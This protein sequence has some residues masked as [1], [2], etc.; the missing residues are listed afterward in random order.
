MPASVRPKRFLREHIPAER[1]VEVHLVVDGTSSQRAVDRKVALKVPLTVLLLQVMIAP[2]L[3]D[4]DVTFAACG[5]KRSLSGHIRNG[6][7][8]A[9]A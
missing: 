9:A 7:V 6:L 8:P 4:A 2:S 1:G 3:V 5:T